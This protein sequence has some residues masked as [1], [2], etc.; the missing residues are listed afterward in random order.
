MMFIV[1][2]PILYL[3]TIPASIGTSKFS[4]YFRCISLVFNKNRPLWYSTKT[5]QLSNPLGNAI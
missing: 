1:L 3:G 2:R 4:S 5:G